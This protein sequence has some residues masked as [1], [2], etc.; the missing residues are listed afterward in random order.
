MHILITGGAGFIGSHSV[1]ALRAAGH[2]VRVFDDL[3]TGHVDNLAGKSVDFVQGD[4]RDA[5]AV[6]RAVDGVDAVLHLAA[7]VSVPLSM[8]APLETFAINTTGTTHVLE[9]ARLSPRMPRVVLASTSAVYGDLPGRK[10][11]LSPIAPL[12]PYGA[13]KLMAEQALS[14]Y[15]RSYGLPVVRLRYFNVYGPRQRADSPYSGVLA[16][17]TA[18]ARAGQECL[19]FGDGEQTRDFV[20]VRDVARAN[21]AALTAPLPEP[22]PLFVVATGESVTLNQVLAALGRAAGASLPVRHDQPRAGDIVHSSADAARLRRAFGW[23]PQ[24]VLQDGLRELLD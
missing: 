18:A 15:S 13:S 7:L 17:W 2:S 24:V 20:H 3:S 21:L 9:A 16:K 23:A 22:D 1:D 11:E 4:L 6:R 5:A 8:R 19:V 12:S 14:V 10:D